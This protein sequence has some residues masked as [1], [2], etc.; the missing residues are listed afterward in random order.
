MGIYLENG[1]KYGGI[2]HELIIFNCPWD[3]EFLGNTSPSC[4]D[5]IIEFPLC[6]PSPRSSNGEDLLGSASIETEQRS[7]AQ[8]GCQADRRFDADTTSNLS[9]FLSWLSLKIWPFP[10]VFLVLKRRLN[11]GW[12]AVDCWSQ[13]VWNADSASIFS[14]GSFVWFYIVQYRGMAAGCSWHVSAL[15]S[16]QDVTSLKPFDYIQILVVLLVQQK[17]KTIPQLS[18]SIYRWFFNLPFPVMGGKHGIDHPVDT[19]PRTGQLW[20]RGI[21][22]PSIAAALAVQKSGFLL[23]WFA[24]EVWAILGGSS[25]LVSE[26]QPWL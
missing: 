23:N 5:A 11:S 6:W 7:L 12:F 13:K 3:W 24:W 8:V 15:R 16:S 25:H 21:T 4:L 18:A 9:H 1:W 10:R 17:Y 20:R 22:K 19:H 14:S 2:L 26:L